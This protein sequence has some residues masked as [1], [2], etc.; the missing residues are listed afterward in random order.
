[1]RPAPAAAPPTARDNKATV[2]PSAAPSRWPPQAPPPPP[3]RRGAI[4]GGD[5]RE[6][7]STRPGGLRWMGVGVG[8]V[9]PG[10]GGGGVGG[11]GGAGSGGR[12][13]EWRAGFFLFGLLALMPW[14][15]T[16]TKQVKSLGRGQRALVFVHSFLS[17]FSPS[18]KKKTRES[19]RAPSRSRST[20]LSHENH[21][22]HAA[23]LHERPSEAVG[24]RSR[25]E[26]TKKG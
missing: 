24:L 11:G 1:L 9:D 18:A 26:T 8:S 20:S 15:L 21:Q 13:E 14:A 22:R 4:F 17:F 7:R 2:I 25:C 3:R 10:G 23:A 12:V 19:S 16:T 6:G 5:S